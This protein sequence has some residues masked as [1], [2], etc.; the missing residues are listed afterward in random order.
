[1]TA[2]SPRAKGGPPPTATSTVAKL[3]PVWPFGYAS[4][5]PASAPSAPPVMRL[6]TERDEWQD[7]A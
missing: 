2:A 4:T 5:I 7:G 1:V 6:N 3:P